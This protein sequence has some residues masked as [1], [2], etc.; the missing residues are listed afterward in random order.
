M[1]LLRATTLVLT[2]HSL[3]AC[4]I[5]NPE[6]PQERTVVKQIYNRS[7]SMHKFQLDFYQTYLLTEQQNH[8]SKNRY[9]P[10]LL[11]DSSCTSA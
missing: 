11:Q 2:S 5:R 4:G 8:H 6:I 1:Q 3:S 10:W 9:S 7:S